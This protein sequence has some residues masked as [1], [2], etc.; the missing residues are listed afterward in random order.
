VFA[1]FPRPDLV[2]PV[3]GHASPSLMARYLSAGQVYV[4]CQQAN[5]GQAGSR[6][7]GVRFWVSPDATLDR[8]TDQA[9]A[10][11]PVRSLAPGQKTAVT[12][13]LLRLGRRLA[14]GEVVYIIAEADS[15]GVVDE[16]DETNNTAVLKVV[17]IQDRW[18][19][20]GVHGA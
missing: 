4:G 19:G 18:F 7:C 1:A 20:V 9:L 3:L 8:G 6:S 11:A 5:Q 16:T 12:N 17:G 15:D 2:V 13:T 14:P 10:L